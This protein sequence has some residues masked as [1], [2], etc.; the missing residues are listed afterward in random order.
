[1]SVDFTVGWILPLLLLGFAVGFL[2]TMFGGGGGFFYVPALTLLFHVP[3]QLAVATSLAS[4]VP[5]TI[6]GSVSHY[7]RGNL[8][9]PVGI[10]FGAGGIIGAL[11]GAYVSSL[12]P[13]TLLGKLFGVFMIILSIAMLFS[14]RE[15]ARSSADTEKASS[16]LTWARGEMSAAFGILS[17]AMAGLFGVSGTPPVIAGLYILGLPAAIV[18]GTSV[19]VLLFNA[20]SGL[21][22][23]LVLGQIN[24]MLTLFLA[25][26]AAAGAFLGPR[27]LGKIKTPTLE[28]VY[29]PLFMVMVIALGV[30]M[31]LR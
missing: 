20:V 27:F 5:T 18:V 31:I 10:A 30:V 28:K 1:M 24:L 23:H 7:R 14:A 2:V 15:R 11:I 21:V 12:I 19:F 6:S 3:T 26:G 4:I 16:S 22:G 17:G 8:N 13:P 29:G 9:I 25:L